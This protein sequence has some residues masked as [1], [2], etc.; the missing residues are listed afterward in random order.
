[1]SNTGFVSTKNWDAK[2]IETLV[3]LR[4]SGV[5]MR[6]IAEQIGKTHNAVKMYV[7]RHGKDLG[8]R[9]AIEFKSRAKSQC[10][11]FDRKW[12]GAVPFGHWT[13]TKPWKKVS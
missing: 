6:K 9:S 12:Y 5:P 7:Q 2:D 1:M 8:L 3:E 11:E 4:N 10:P 13:I